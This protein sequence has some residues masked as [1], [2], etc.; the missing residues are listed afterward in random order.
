MQN[1]KD[2]FY[3]TLRSRLAA[4]NPLRTMTL[5]SVARPSILVEEA[6]APMAQPVLD[7]FALIWTG[8]QADHQLPAIL[9]QMTCEIRYSTAGTQNNAGLDRG[10]ALEEMDYEVLNLLYP[11]SAQKMNYTQNPAA[12]METMIFWSEPEFGAVVTLRDR[13][14]RTAKVTV[15]AFQEPGYSSGQGSLGPQEQIES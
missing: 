7:A 8:L 3:I 10:R 1:A 4:L 5:R 11:Y 2:T 14:S 12:A 9:A 6:E 13:L 15:F